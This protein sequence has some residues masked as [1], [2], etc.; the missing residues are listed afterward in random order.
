MTPEFRCFPAKSQPAL[1]V[2][3]FLIIT[4]RPVLIVLV[5][6]VYREFWSDGVDLR[7]LVFFR[8]IS[9]SFTRLTTP[10]RYSLVSSLDGRVNLATRLAIISAALCTPGRTRME[11]FRVGDIFSSRQRARCF[12][13]ARC[14]LLRCCRALPLVLTGFFVV[15]RLLP[16][17][18]KTRICVPGKCLVYLFLSF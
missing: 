9:G 16:I 4:R 18:W 5:L 10:P 12:F 6:I 1:L 13:F 2:A 15:A 3:R 7:L 14:R 8:I 17:C 11:Q